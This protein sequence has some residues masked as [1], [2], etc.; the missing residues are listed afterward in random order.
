[1]QK[2][3][4]VANLI[5]SS[6]SSCNA[7]YQS[8][9]PQTFGVRSILLFVRKIQ[10]LEYRSSWTSYYRGCDRLPRIARN[11]KRRFVNV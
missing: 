9:L 1:L 7:R 11:G 6:H 8:S 3:I 10:R 4:I 5:H 2:L